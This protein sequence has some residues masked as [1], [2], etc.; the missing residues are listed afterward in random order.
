[1]VVVI[2]VVITLI[3]GDRLCGVFTY[4]VP[5]N[6]FV[7]VKA[8]YVKYAYNILFNV[9][10]SAASRILRCNAAVDA[11]IIDTL[12]IKIVTQYVQRLDKRVENELN[13]IETILSIGTIRYFGDLTVFW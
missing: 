3:N 6:V 4:H 10:H 2:V 11:H 9:S 7:F 13:T 12:G 1:M 8:I 5:P